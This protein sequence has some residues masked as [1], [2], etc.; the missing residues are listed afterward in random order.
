LRGTPTLYYGDELGMDNVDIPRE[1]VVDPP[2]ITLGVG[3]D[4]ERTPMLWDDS[5]NAGFTTA[6]EP[7]LP[8]SPDY[9][10]INV[11]A[12]RE[13]AHS[14]LT[15]HRRLIHLRQSE[16]ALKAGA[17]SPVPADGDILAFSRKHDGEGF[18]V[19]LN[20]SSEPQ[21]VEV[22]PSD[23]GRIALSTYLD[24]EGDIVSGNIGLRADEGV[25]IRLG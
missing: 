17:Y 9:A 21:L 25:I 8:V 12:Q 6:P 15:L 22:D 20:F 7:W 1:K 19:V 23:T 2:G 3:R 16:A 10:D 13:D 18:L 5:A 14:M 4:P 11:E 24:R